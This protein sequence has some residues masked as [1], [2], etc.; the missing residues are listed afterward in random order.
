MSALNRL[1]A[2]PWDPPADDALESWLGGLA[3]DDGDPGAWD[4]SGVVVG[5]V[6]GPVALAGAPV[7]QAKVG[8]RPYEVAG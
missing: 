6:V 3:G 1:D 4:G 5:L 2:P 7:E 8:R